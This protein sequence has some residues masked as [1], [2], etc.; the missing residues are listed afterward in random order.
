MK[1]RSILLGLMFLPLFC[2]VAVP[3]RAQT[4]NDDFQQAV[5]AYLQSHNVSTATN[6]IKLAAAMDQLPPIPEEARRH[7]VS[8]TTLFKQAKSTDDIKQAADEFEQA[9]RLAPW[10]PEA[11]FNYALALYEALPPIQAA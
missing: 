3:A 10:W 8:G 4:G 1:A 11:R 2:A 6:V 7:Y 9:T 5:A